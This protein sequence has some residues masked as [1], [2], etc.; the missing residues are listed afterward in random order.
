MYIQNVAF[1]RP[2]KALWLEKR[3]APLI[4]SKLAHLGHPERSFQAILC[5]VE[6]FSAR[7]PLLLTLR[8][9]FFVGPIFQSPITLICRSAHPA[10]TLPMEL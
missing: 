1:K 2:W 5:G 7:L 6:L 9:L 8:P 4:E 10:D 3:P